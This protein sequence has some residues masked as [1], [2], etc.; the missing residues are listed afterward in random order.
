MPGTGERPVFGRAR[1]RFPRHSVCPYGWLPELGT[2]CPS[3]T[4]GR[5][6][7]ARRACLILTCRRLT[8]LH[9][10]VAGLPRPCH[11]WGASSQV[12]ADSALRTR[13]PLALVA[14]AHALCRL[15]LAHAGTPPC[16]LLARLQ[17]GA[18]DRSISPCDRTL[19]RTL[20]QAL[21]RRRDWR[22]TRR[23]DGRNHGRHD[24]RHPRIIST[25]T[26]PRVPQD[27]LPPKDTVR[28]ARASATVY[29]CRN[30][31]R[32]VAHPPERQRGALSI[33]RKNHFNTVC[34][35]PFYESCQI[36]PF[37]TVL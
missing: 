18:H 35:V 4:R 21:A 32:E 10:P 17:A 15:R 25:V 16:P 26:P 14:L 8:S 6:R 29:R 37:V 19:L 3:A 27:A 23:L 31:Y 12:F 24:G 20:P 13:T 1:G 9:A 28:R 11:W 2:P 36:A 30:G 34:N 22:R 7:P 33:F 5:L